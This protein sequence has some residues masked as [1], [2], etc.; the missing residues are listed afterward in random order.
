MT[1]QQKD[2]RAQNLS[3]KAMLVSVKI[4]R[5]SGVR[6]DKI[7]GAD[8]AKLKKANPERAG[9]YSKNV[10][11]TK[12]THVKAIRET[13]GKA[14]NHFY[15]NSVPWD[16]SDGKSNGPRMVTTLAYDELMTEL[17]KFQEQFNRDV[18]AC[19]REMPRLK[20]DAMGYLGDMFVEDEYPDAEAFEALHSFEIDMTFMPENDPRLDIKDEEYERIKAEIEAKTEAKANNVTASLADEMTGV[21]VNLVER[22]EAFGHDDDGKVVGNFHDTLI[23]NIVHVCG[24][25][26]NYNIQGDPALEKARRD[27]VHRLTAH[28]PAD[29]KEDANLRAEVKGAAK[30]IM[31]DMAD[32]YG[33]GDNADAS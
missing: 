29:L 9:K 21:M 28:T 20:A 22:M 15:A 2:P 13:G 8:L 31:A 26:Q 5:W 3:Q 17:A 16:D 7:A 12:D 23:G 14:R 27:M 25:V 32:I 19:S 4:K 24:K 18:Q 6:N 30:D 10:I 33:D 1:D 11:D